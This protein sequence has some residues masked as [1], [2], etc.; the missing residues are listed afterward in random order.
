MHNKS[1]K[2]NNFRTKLSERNIEAKYTNTSFFLQNSK[3]EKEKKTRVLEVLNADFIPQT[4]HK[5]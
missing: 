3:T 1:L 2:G 5:L 4:A